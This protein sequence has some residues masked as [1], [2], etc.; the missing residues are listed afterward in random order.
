MQLLKYR[1]CQRRFSIPWPVGQ[2]G[3]VENRLGQACS[4]GFGRQRANASHTGGVWASSK[5]EMTGSSRG[6]VIIGSNLRIKLTMW[7]SLPAATRLRRNSRDVSPVRIFPK[8]TGQGQTH[9]REIQKSDIQKLSCLAQPHTE[10]RHCQ[11]ER[12]QDCRR[13]WQSV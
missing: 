11:H 13:G 10:T 12:L 3:L 8:T 4:A 9:L 1:G 6:R 7:L 5:Y 2:D